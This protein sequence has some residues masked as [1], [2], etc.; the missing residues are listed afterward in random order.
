M[1]SSPAEANL[2]ADPWVT[3]FLTSMVIRFLDDVSA[4]AEVD[5]QRV[6]GVVEGFDHIREPKLRGHHGGI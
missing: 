5:Y 3:C 6:I 1:P 2:V 4:T